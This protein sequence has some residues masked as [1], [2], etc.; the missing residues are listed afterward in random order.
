MSILFLCNHQAVPNIEWSVNKFWRIFFMSDLAATNCGCNDDRT[1]CGCGCGCNGGTGLGTFGGDSCSC[2]LWFI[3]LMSLCGN[4]GFGRSG[5]GCGTD[6]CWIL[7][8]LLLL[9]GN[10]GCGC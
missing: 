10:N 2:I 3:I 9:C 4:N 5:C 6:S 7:V 8:V 1:S